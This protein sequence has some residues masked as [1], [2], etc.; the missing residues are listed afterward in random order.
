MLPKKHPSHVRVEK[1]LLDAVRIEVCIRMPVMVTV[2]RRPG[3]R[4]L[5][6]RRRPEKQNEEADK[7]I[8]LV[9]GM[10]KKPVIAHRDAE[11]CGHDEEYKK[12]NVFRMK[13]G[14]P[15]IPRRTDKCARRGCDEKKDAGPIILPDHI[16]RE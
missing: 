11:R 6:K 15:Q 7:R 4:R 16:L 2:C 1:S 12:E 9:A 8:G 14:M 5:L 10:R 3:Q 13:A